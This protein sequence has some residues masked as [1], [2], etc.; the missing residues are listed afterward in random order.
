VTNQ[1][2]DDL[3]Q[4]SSK[5][6]RTCERSDRLRDVEP[7]PPF[8]H[9]FCRNAQDRVYFVALAAVLDPLRTSARRPAL[10]SWRL[11]NLGLLARR[12]M[13]LYG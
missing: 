9:T 13:K 6:W 3:L 11:W 1:D 5:N 8:S 2:S 4:R 7:G 12:A 10:A